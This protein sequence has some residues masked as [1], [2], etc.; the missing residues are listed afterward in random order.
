MFFYLGLWICLAG[1]AQQGQQ[2]THL[3]EGLKSL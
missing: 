3:V 1:S 2:S